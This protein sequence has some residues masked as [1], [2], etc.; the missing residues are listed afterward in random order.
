MER[1]LVVGGGPA[2]MTTAIALGRLGADGVAA[3]LSDGSTESVDLVVGA[4]GLHSAVRA[5]VLPGAPGPRRAP[6]LI[7]R[8]SAPRPPEVDRYLLHDLG[9][10]GRVGLVP[11]SEG[12]LYL[13]LLQRDDGAPRPAAQQRLAALRERLAPF[14]GAVPLVRDQLRDDVDHRSLAAL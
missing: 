6:Q 11:I 7:W 5:M 12:E 14:G 8:A 13:W 10:L 4:D 2:G 3:E 1:A 9:P